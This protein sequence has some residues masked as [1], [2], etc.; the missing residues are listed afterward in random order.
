VQT[1]RAQRLIAEA[2]GLVATAT[3]LLGND[4][5]NPETSSYAFR[6]AST[7]YGM[8]TCLDPVQKQLT[9]AIPHSKMNTYWSGKTD[10]DDLRTGLLDFVFTGD[11]GSPMIGEELAAFEVFREKYIGVMCRSHP[12][13]AAVRDNNISVHQWVSCNHI[14]FY[15]GL[16]ATS[17]V[18]RALINYQIS[19]EIVFSSPSHVMNIACL[20]GSLFM[21]SL[22]SRLRFLL[23]ESKFL[24]FD[25]PIKVP[26][27]PFFLVHHTSISEISALNFARNLILDYFRVTHA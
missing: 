2:R 18:D 1:A 22:P 9:S 10:F 14:Q 5:F 26:E 4:E 12:L 24:V 11:I 21:Y 17:S 6:F 27:Y 20:S 7:E 19:R 25:L 13:A 16:D 23:D 8:L 3:R 15:T